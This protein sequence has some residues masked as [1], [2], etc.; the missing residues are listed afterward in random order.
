MWSGTFS[1]LSAESLNEW[2][3][4]FGSWSVVVAIVGIPL[5]LVV[6]TYMLE[7]A[8]ILVNHWMG[9]AQKKAAESGVIVNG[10]Q[11]F[12]SRAEAEKRLKGSGYN[13]WG[14]QE[15]T[16]T[17]GRVRDDGRVDKT[18]LTFWDDVK[19]VSGSRATKVGPVKK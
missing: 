17:W 11:G 9:V 16:E 7:G 4:K 1:K 15:H 2:F 14:T 6:F 10:A 5:A 18:T 8:M 19:G 3:I 12:T 13:R